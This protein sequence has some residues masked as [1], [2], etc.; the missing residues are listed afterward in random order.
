ML[1]LADNMA[2]RVDE[3]LLFAQLLLADGA[4]SA[5]LDGTHP[6]TQRAYLQAVILQ[7]DLA[8][9]C[10]CGEISGAKPSSDVLGALA[11]DIPEPGEDS[12]LSELR[13]LQRN[14]SSWLAQLGRFTNQI[15]KGQAPRPSPEHE[16]S[17]NLIAVSGATGDFWSEAS[18]ESI[19][20]I[21]SCLVRCI[22]N[23]RDLAQE[24]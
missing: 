6:Q 16:A 19:E 13:E 3:H 20:N 8:L 12:R 14:E 9:V 5:C 17:A 4:R 11:A 15:R 2:V 7:L 24:Y 21:R 22:A 10:Y 1:P 18:L 23:Q